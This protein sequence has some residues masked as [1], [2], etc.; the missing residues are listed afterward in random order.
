MVAVIGFN[1]VHV[2]AFAALIVTTQNL[3]A[4]ILCY[5]MQVSLR[6]CTVKVLDYRSY[7]TSKPT[8]SYGSIAIT[9]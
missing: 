1:F 7:R 2:G 9:F 6:T 4:S 8:R 5:F 3:L